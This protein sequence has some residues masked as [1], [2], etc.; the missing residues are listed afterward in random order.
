MSDH[1]R[2]KEKTNWSAR[3]N[4]QL[5]Q[6][7]CR[8]LWDYSRSHSIAEDYD[9]YFAFN[10]LF[11]FD[12][13]IVARYLQPPG[14][15][16]DLGCGTGRA[17]FPLLRAGY[18]GLAVDLS[19]NML[20][21]VKEKAEMV[22]HASLHCLR[23]NLVQLDGLKDASVDHV[24]CLFSTLG[25]I[26]GRENRRQS[27]RHMRRILRPSGRCVLHVH[28]YW[29]NLRDPG[30]PFWLVKNLLMAPFSS[31]IEVGDKWF[32]YRGLSNMF[33]HVFRWNELAGDL[34]HAGLKVLK[35]IRLD[36]SRRHELRWPWLL[37]ALRTNGW[38]VVCEA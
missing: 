18:Q 10:T 25:M 26:R 27:L 16:A 8:G 31:S 7:V 30:G 1:P 19:E 9:D 38:I 35:R 32:P 22:P 36:T 17:L 12:E 5:P 14:L 24:I 23:A 29:Y 37:P 6:G 13:E 33:L 28:N 20:S 3:A 34:R 11:D 15:V 21:V 2:S 4:W